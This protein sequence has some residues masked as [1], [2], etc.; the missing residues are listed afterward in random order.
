MRTSSRKSFSVIILA[1]IVVVLLM[2]NSMVM[3][4]DVAN[5]TT[6]ATVVAALTVTASSPLAFGTVYQ[7]V[8]KSISKNV[9]D[10]AVFDITGQANADLLLYVSLPEFIATSTGDDRMVISFTATDADIDT[11]LVGAGDPATFVGGWQAEDPHNLMGVAG[12]DPCLGDAG[13]CAI[14]IG[15]KVI[16]TLDQTAGAYTGDIILTVAYQGT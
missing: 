16:P 15:G 11:A 1:A 9:A 14:F 2:S 3:A 13:L 8:P 6:T 7:G 10:A 5:G 4:Q 12:G